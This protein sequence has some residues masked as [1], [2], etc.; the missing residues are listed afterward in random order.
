VLSQLSGAKFVIASINQFVLSNMR[1]L[2]PS[3]MHAQDEIF[4]VALCNLA[5]V[6]IAGRACPGQGASLLKFTAPSRLIEVHSAVDASSGTN[7]VITIN[8]E[9]VPINTR[10]LTTLMHACKP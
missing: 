9:V 5:L 7:F 8:S 1:F 4:V 2:K 3:C 10:L 6:V